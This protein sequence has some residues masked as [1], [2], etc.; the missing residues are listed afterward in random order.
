VITA[1]PGSIA[2][3]D[4]VIALMD[5]AVAWLTGQGRSGQWGSEPI[6][7]RAQSV[8]KMRDEVE[9]NDLWMAEIDRE[10]VGAMLLGEVPMPYVAPV[11][12]RELYLH[13]LITSRRY[14]GHGIGQALVDQARVVAKERGID[15]IRVDCY[16]GD[17]RK[18]VAAYERLGFAPTETFT[19][20]EWPG[21]VLAMRISESMSNMDI[22]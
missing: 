21:Q 19:V 6:S 5:E 9:L 14:A 2:D 22:A 13:L 17:D 11:D 3:F 10:P 4:T 8:Q 1:R 12:E 16:A 20:K 7:S 18:L 15:L